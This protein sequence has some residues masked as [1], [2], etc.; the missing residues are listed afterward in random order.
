[1]SRVHGP[2][3]SH[4]LV[5]R[6]LT[7]GRFTTLLTSLHAIHTS[8]GRKGEPTVTLSASLA[9]RVRAGEI[10]PN[11]KL[12]LY[13]NYASKVQDRYTAHRERYAALD[14]QHAS[15]AER[16]ISFLQDYEAE[17]RAIAARVIH[18][19]P[20]FSNLILTVDNQVVFI[21][22]RG[23][24]EG[25]LTLQ[26]DALYDLAKVL[27]SCVG[28]ITSRAHLGAAFRA[29]TLRSWQTQPRSSRTVSRRSSCPP[30]ARCW[31]SSRTR[32]GRSSR[33]TVR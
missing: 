29:T 24:Q 14:E 20:V 23:S 25:R 18:G 13:T 8:P 11:D 30:I 21:D 10:G 28:P 16:L 7:L 3:F 15:L 19:D 4:L 22:P 27:Q 5:G 32:F 31:L 2:T 26:G 12:D 6:A 9:N 33:S 17:D 1:M